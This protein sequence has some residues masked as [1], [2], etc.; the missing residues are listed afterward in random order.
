MRKGLTYGIDV[1]IL[2][3]V[4]NNSCANDLHTNNSLWN[5]LTAVKERD[6]AV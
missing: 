4:A 5:D 2:C 3:L 6:T 1:I